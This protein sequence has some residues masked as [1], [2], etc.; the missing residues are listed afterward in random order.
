MRQETRLIK[1]LMATEKQ[2]LFG[3]HKVQENL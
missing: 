3:I 1:S 2:E